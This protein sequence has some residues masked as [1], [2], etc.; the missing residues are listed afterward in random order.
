MQGTKP[1][2][3]KE[4]IANEINSGTYNFMAKRIINGAFKFMR[5]IIKSS[6]YN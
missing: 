5:K 4:F 1:L 6:L 3:L 2:R